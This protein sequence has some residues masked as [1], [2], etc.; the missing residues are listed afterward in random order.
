MLRHTTE[1]VLD[2]CVEAIEPA[3]AAFTS[4]LRNHVTEDLMKGLNKHSWFD[5]FDI[6]DELPQKYTLKEWIKH[7]KEVKATVFIAGSTFP[8]LTVKFCITFS[9]LVNEL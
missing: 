2:A 9:L 7:A 5:G 8:H 3:R 1:E 6:P 4:S